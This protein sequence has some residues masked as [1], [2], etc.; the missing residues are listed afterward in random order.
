MF[1]PFRITTEGEMWS[2]LVNITVLTEK[3]RPQGG[4]SLFHRNRAAPLPAWPHFLRTLRQLGS[5]DI[6]VRIEPTERI[7]KKRRVW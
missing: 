2:E 3:P 1:T 7:K 4:A 5:H 6:S